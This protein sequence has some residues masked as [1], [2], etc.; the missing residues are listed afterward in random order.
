MTETL[1]ATRQ[2]KHWNSTGPFRDRGLL[3]AYPSS[4]APETPP[5][6]SGVVTS[7][8]FSQFHHSGVIS[9][10]CSWVLSILIRLLVFFNI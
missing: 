1:I 8:P 7:W 2:V 4:T 9:Q 6:R 10:S 5:P 3:C